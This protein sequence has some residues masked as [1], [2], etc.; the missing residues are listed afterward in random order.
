MADFARWLPLS[1]RPTGDESGVT[2]DWRPDAAAQF[3]ALAD[4]V[5]RASPEAWTAPGGLDPHPRTTAADEVLR[6]ISRQ[7][8]G[9]LARIP[10][11]V[12]STP[13][14]PGTA[15]VRLRR[16][17]AERRAGRGPRGI[18]EV[19]EVVGSRIRLARRLGSPHP[20]PEPLAGAI[21]LHRTLTAP[22]PIRSVVRGRTI[23]STDAGWAYGTGPEL[24]GTTAVLLDFL[25]GVG[26]APR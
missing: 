10:G 23:R 2:G 21:A 20:L 3:A 18:R 1:S 5:E 25:F 17:A 11:A 19:A 26:P 8:G 13:L 22:A 14:D 24:A 4:A 9:R 7:E 15:A 16:L 12:D 6:L